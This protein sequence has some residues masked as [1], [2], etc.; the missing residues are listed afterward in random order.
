MIVL[1][2]PSDPRVKGI[3]RSPAFLKGHQGQGEL[4]LV[5]QDLYDYEIRDVTGEEFSGPPTYQTQSGQIVSRPDLDVLLNGAPISF[6]EC[7]AYHGPDY[8]RNTDTIEHGCPT[9]LVEAYRV[10]QQ[11]SGLPVFIYVIEENREVQE[12]RRKDGSI[13]KWWEAPQILRIDLDNLLTYARK[14]DNFKNRDTRE[15]EPW[16]YWPRS[17]MRRLCYRKMPVSNRNQGG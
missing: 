16:I 5:L 17:H 9:R 1:P 10:V 13:F 15:R 12:F 8:H 6:A 2:D 7:K 4:E 3:A 11:D 14:G